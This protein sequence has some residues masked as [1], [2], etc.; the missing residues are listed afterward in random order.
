MKTTKSDRKQD[1]FA[2]IAAQQTEWR[3]EALIEPQPPAL[4][5]SELPAGRSNPQAS[6]K[7]LPKLDTPEKLQRALERERRRTAPFLRDLTPAI[8]SNRIAAPIIACDWRLETEADRRDFGATLAGAGEW[9]RVSLPHY[10]GPVG[11][12][13]AYY[14]RTTFEV[15]RAMLDKGSVWV[16]FKGVDY[17]ARVFVNGAF[18]GS[19]E[20]FFARF[21]FD[22]TPQARLGQNVLVVK[23]ENDAC[24]ISDGGSW[25]MTVA[26]DKLKIEG[27][28]MGQRH[29]VSRAIGHP[30]VEGFGPEGFRLWH[31]PAVDRIAPLLETCFRAEG[32]TPTLTTGSGGGNL[33]APTAWSSA[34]AAAEK[35]DGAGVWRI[36]QVALA[37]RTKTN[38]VAGLFAGRMLEGS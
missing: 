21:A 20:G 8:E 33:T 38:P 37:G 24:S 18:L 26:G 31:D 2:N 35:R 14:Y 36:C 25:G 27:C 15:T 9:Q 1:V 28:G 19:H 6:F 4:P 7:P 3:R 13:A 32:W 17:Q 16:C 10:G 23:V 5:E 34:L 12:A 29:F 30:L 11:R 22:F